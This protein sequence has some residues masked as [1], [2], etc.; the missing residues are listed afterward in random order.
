MVGGGPALG[1]GR[2]RISIPSLYLKQ[3]NTNQN[4][5]P[6]PSERTNQMAE[7]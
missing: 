6:V 4:C 1:S 5:F 7:Y 2:L 3:F